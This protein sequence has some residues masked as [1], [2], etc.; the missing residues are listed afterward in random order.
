MNPDSL[1]TFPTWDSYSYHDY[2]DVYSNSG[3]RSQRW[4]SNR[5]DS[6]DD[7]WRRH[8]DVEDLIADIK[9]P[10]L[11]EAM[12]AKVDQLEMIYD[13]YIRD[14]SEKAYALVSSRLEEQLKRQTERNDKLEEDF[15]KLKAE[16]KDRMEDYVLEHKLQWR[17]GISDAPKVCHFLKFQSIWK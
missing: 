10:D 8:K 1:D 5:Y 16:I 11:Q 2:L 15:R 4:F 14:A 3:R 13:E 17:M 7:D 12:V 6:L 9:D